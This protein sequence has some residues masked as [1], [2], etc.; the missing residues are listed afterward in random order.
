MTI[1]KNVICILAFS[2]VCLFMPIGYAQLSNDLLVNTTV[3]AE[4]PLIV[5]ITDAMISDS[6]GVNSNQSVINYYSTTLVSS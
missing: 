3:S 5:Y 6:S 1:L 4:P 2:F